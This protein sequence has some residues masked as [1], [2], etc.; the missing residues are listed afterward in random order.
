[1]VR[2][3]IKMTSLLKRHMR[4]R[5]IAMNISH[6][7]VAT[8]LNWYLSENSKLYSIEAFNFVSSKAVEK[9]FQT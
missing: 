6:Y 8:K 1:M 4:Y 7:S 5:L 3:A 9:A 2:N